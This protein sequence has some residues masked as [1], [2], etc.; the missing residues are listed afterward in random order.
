MKLKFSCFN[1]VR[2][3]TMSSNGNGSWDCF[4]NNQH[5]DSPFH[6]HYKSTLKSTSIPVYTFN[7]IRRVLH[8]LG[9]QPDNLFK[10]NETINITTVFPVCSLLPIEVHWLVFFISFPYHVLGLSA[11]VGWITPIPFYMSNI[12]ISYANNRQKYNASYG[13]YIFPGF[14]IYKWMRKKSWRNPS[15]LTTKKLDHSFCVNLYIRH[16]KLVA[17]GPHAISEQL[18]VPRGL[19]PQS[20][21]SLW[22]IMVFLCNNR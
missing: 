1:M 19:L 16:V 7:C 8:K 11:D 13:F 12:D 2:I 10:R 9:E 5:L 6:L 18:P 3:Q 4:T 17:H 22:S 14:L 15:A 21:F 20:L